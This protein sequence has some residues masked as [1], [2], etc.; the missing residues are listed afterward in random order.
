MKAKWFVEEPLWTKL[1]NLTEKE[2][3]LPRG[4]LMRVRGK[5]MNV[6]RVTANGN[7]YPRK[8]VEKEI[9]R[10]L[11]LMEARDVIMLRDHPELRE[12]GSIN[13]PKMKDTAAVLIDLSISDDDEVWFEADIIDKEAGR[14]VASHVLAG[15][16]AGVSTRSRG[17][18][19][20]TKLTEQHPLAKKNESWIG[21]EINFINEDLELKTGDFVVEPAAESAGIASFRE[22]ENLEE[23][24]FD[25]EK[26]TKEEWESI[27][28]HKN[29]K[30]AIE[31]AVKEEK[32]KF[33][34]DIATR[35]QEQVAEFIKSDEFVA[36]FEDEDDPKLVEC[37]NCKKE[38]PEGAE[39]CLHCGTKQVIVEKQVNQD[40]KDEKID[41][42]KKT[43]EAVNKKLS[44]MEES[45]KKLSDER[46]A[47]KTK[48]AVECK[49]DELLKGK[50]AI[51]CENV[52]KKLDTSKLTLEDV[53]ESV[54]DQ[55]KFVEDIV[56]LS[57]GN[58]NLPPGKGKVI[59][60]DDFGTPKD[61]AKGDMDYLVE[62]MKS[63]R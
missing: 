57:G 58:I 30:S 39:F 35:V 63:F 60:D 19:T 29:V 21:K 50:P 42:L 33:E 14:D 52:R 15:V 25:L 36:M 40:E 48:Q 27:L 38:L 31:A 53:E 6:D 55:V 9:A 12:D 56:S 49:V 11:P 17:T 28:T 16:K 13:S 24:M 1:E 43:L 47:E 61:D 41:E 7:L 44:E 37:V 59:K 51:I 54:K 22:E 62:G 18:A 32:E 3:S 2:D 26:L 5:F 23:H 46:E 8:V 45:N 34:A 4:V 20:I 10:L